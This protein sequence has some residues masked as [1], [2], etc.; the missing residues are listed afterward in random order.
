MGMDVYG[1]KPKSE[2]GKYFRANIWSWR[3]IHRLVAELCGD[4]LDEETLV[5]MGYN[6]GSG[7]RSANVCRQMADRFDEWLE[8][9]TEG[10][11]IEH[12]S[13]R[14]DADGRF[15]SDKELAA[16]PSL[17]TRSPYAVEDEDLKEWVAFLRACG[18]FEVW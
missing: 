5:G 16:N 11:V 15:V 3:P 18:G 9:N 2:A 8:H 12:A 14:V 1:R 6:Q 10:A 7:P 13:M 4:L 17:E